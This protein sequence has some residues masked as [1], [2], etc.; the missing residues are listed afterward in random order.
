MLKKSFASKVKSHHFRQR[1]AGGKNN[2]F[3]LTLLYQQMLFFGP[4]R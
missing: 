3:P 2:L 4:S 1:L